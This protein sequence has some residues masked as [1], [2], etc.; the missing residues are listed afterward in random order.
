MEAGTERKQ[1]KL[2][3]LRDICTKIQEAARRDTGDR[4][5]Q[6]HMDRWRLKKRLTG[7][8]QELM[9][10]SW[11]SHKQTVKVGGSEVGRL[12]CR[13]NSAGTS[14]GPVVG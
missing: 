5:K 7:G 11:Q 10:E 3:F 6:T 8:K 9:D 4:D 2:K 12:C 1:A 14:L 13:C